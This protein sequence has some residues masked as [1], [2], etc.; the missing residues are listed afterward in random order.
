MPTSVGNVFIALAV[1]QFKHLLADFVLQTPAMV[2]AKG[3][4]GRSGGLLHAA[5]HVVGS[6]P[7]LVWFS[8]DGLAISLILV[9]EFLIHYHVDWCKEKL[10]QRLGMSPTRGWFWFATGVDQMLHQ[11]TYLGMLGWIAP[12]SASIGY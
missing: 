2:E 12:I 6:T 8:S 9:A 10:N 3:H 4:Y 7:V 11:L 1:L 5:I